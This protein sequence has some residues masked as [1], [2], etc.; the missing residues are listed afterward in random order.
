MT[1]ATPLTI[2]SG[3]AWNLAGNSLYS[4]AQWLL[5]VILARL[6]APSEVGSFAL[7]LAISAPV[8]MTAG[9]NLRLVQATDATQ[10]W[11]LE[12]YLALRHLVNGVAVVVTMVVGMVVGFDADLLAALLAVSA[13]KC[14]ES[15]SQTYYGFFQQHERHDF[16]SHS[17]LVRSVAGPAFFCAGYVITDQLAGAALG[18]LV[19]W[20]IP[21]QLLDRRRARRIRADGGRPIAALRPVRW[22]EIRAL[23][24]KAFPLGLD[25]GISSVAANTPRYFVQGILGPAQLGIYSSLSYLAQ[26]I[27]MISSALGT[28][29]MPRLAQYHRDG[30]QAAFVRLLALQTLF[31]MAVV[32]VAIVVGWF[33]GE[34]FVR[35]TLGEEYVDQ[36]LFMV[37]LIGAGAVTLQ[38]CVGRGLTGA[39]RFASFFVLD[40]LTAVGVAVASLLLVPEWGLIGAAWATVVGFTLGAVAAVVPVARVVRSMRASEA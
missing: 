24:R 32:V 25:Q 12:D 7:L 22:T 9:L 31:S 23:A 37:L 36:E 14:V 15:V 34:P 39:Q 21:Q 28:A 2:R 26:A 6:A 18:L 4:L 11:R 35:M 10:R 5:L 20:S 8:F 33:L 29:V 27:S 13:A 17:L 30:R 3:F 19:G 1:G 38:R 16:V 40:T